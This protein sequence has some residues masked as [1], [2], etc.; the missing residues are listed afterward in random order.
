LRAAEAPALLWAALARVSF[1]QVLR[2]A[3]A[4][5]AASAAEVE[6]EASLI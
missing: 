2:V 6:V 4:L 1:P 5:P 3:D